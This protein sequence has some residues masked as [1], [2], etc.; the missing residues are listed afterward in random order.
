MSYQYITAGIC[1]WKWHITNDICSAKIEELAA[2]AG[3]G[4]DAAR[5]TSRGICSFLSPRFPQNDI[6]HISSG[7]NVLKMEIDI[8][9]ILVH[10]VAQISLES[11][12]N[13]ANNFV[14]HHKKSYFVT[15]SV[16]LFG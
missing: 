12:A 3:K 13:I 15:L 14:Y 11:N 4:A 2:G 1:D 5:E 6:F 9:H 8:S 10:F 7:L 16:I